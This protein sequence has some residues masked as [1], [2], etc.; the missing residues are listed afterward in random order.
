MNDEPQQ[1][2][3]DYALPLEGANAACDECGTLGAF[4]F[5][6]VKLCLHCYSEKG[7]CC[8]EFGKD[9]LW[10]DHTVNN[11]KPQTG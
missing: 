2:S 5:Q 4:T 1:P 8:P 6:G 10:K 11:P 9:D 3:K 7:S